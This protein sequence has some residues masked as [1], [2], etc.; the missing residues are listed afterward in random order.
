[1][2]DLVE[3]KTF[4]IGEVRSI[5]VRALAKRIGSSVK[6]SKEKLQKMTAE[7]DKR[8]REKIR[9]D[10]EKNPYSRRSMR[11]RKHMKDM[12]SRKNMEE[13]HKISGSIKQIGSV[14]KEKL[15]Q[16]LIKRR[17]KREEKLQAYAR[18]H[19]KLAQERRKRRLASEEK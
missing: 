9:A 19:Y 16:M 4:S 17:K 11:I 12:R 1:M 14:S 13:A 15:R 8:A 5:G 10:Y 18:K 3:R 2:N 7:H 6:A